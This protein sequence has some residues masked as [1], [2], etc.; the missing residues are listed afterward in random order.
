MN[1]SNIIEL[2]VSKISPN[3]KQP[4]QYFDENRLVELSDSLKKHGMLQPVVV[5]KTKDG[6]ILIDGERRYRA[7]KMSKMKVI[8]AI[9]WEV[10]DDKDLLTK[11]FQLQELRESWTSIERAK[12]IIALSEYYGREARQL[13][14]EINVPVRTVDDYMAYATLVN[15][16]AFERE[17]VALEWAPKVKS[18]ARA[19][20]KVKIEDGKDFD[21]EQIGKFEE[22]I[23]RNIKS[24]AILT[25]QNASELR[26]AILSDP[27]V[28]DKIMKSAHIETATLTST[29]S[30]R[31]QRVYNRMSWQ[32][33]YTTKIIKE[34]AV[35]DVHKIA[36]K[37]MAV[38]LKTLIKTAQQFVDKLE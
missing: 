13:A 12:A 29:S 1:Q 25:K 15:K 18:L 11:Q 21:D 36:E 9:V 19:A 37:S 4:R 16:E 24:G 22:A 3:E 32:V 34:A 2:E 17:K 35:L 14:H 5:Q 26:S 27:S 6:Y 7:A 10:S 33:Q 38:T 28:V 23:V 31:Q 8:P 30:A 20:T